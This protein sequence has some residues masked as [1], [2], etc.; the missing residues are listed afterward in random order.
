[1]HPWQQQDSMTTH[2]M[3]SRACSTWAFSSSAPWRSFSSSRRRSSYSLRIRL[4]S[5][6]SSVLHLAC[7]QPTM[8]MLPEVMTA[9]AG[10]HHTR[11]V[12]AC[13]WPAAAAAAGPAPGMQPNRHAHAARGHDSHAVQLQS[14]AVAQKLQSCIRACRATCLWAGNVL[15]QKAKCLLNVWPGCACACRPQHWSMDQV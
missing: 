14:L 10:A 4:C 3:L 6:A 12:S 7:S 5:L 2:E 11:C 9:F 13:A 15:E 1:M 8:G